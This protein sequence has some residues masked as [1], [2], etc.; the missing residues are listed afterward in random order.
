ML[1]LLAFSREIVGARVII[2]VRVNSKP[3]TALEPELSVFLAQSLF[4][5]LFVLSFLLSSC[6]TSSTWQIENVVV[7]L[8][9]NGGVAVKDVRYRSRCLTCCRAWCELVEGVSVVLTC[10]IDDL[11]VAQ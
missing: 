10:V 7:D 5:L 1:L 4:L 11:T 9:G 6:L 3:S 2:D 8:E